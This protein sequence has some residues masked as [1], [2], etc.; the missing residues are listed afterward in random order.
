[1]RLYNRPMDEADIANDRMQQDLDARL[2][3]MRSRQRLGGPEF[4]DECQ[5]PMP[6]LRRDLGLDL[7]IECATQAERAAK[8]SGRR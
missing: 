2:A 5:T 6:R 4:C 1:M 8:F 7:C 3:A